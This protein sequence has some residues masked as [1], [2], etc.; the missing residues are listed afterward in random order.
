[1]VR[2]SGIRGKKLGRA[3]LFGG[4]IRR[5]VVNK[6]LERGKKNSLRNREETRAESL[7]VRGRAEVIKGSESR[8]TEKRPYQKA[9]GKKRHRPRTRGLA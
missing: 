1:M 4:I 3:I 7:R 8:K 5:K 6:L 2:R 9:R